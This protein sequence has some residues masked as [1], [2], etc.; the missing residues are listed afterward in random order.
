MQYL[1][2]V[3][4]RRLSLKNK[5]T[6]VV[7]FM[8]ANR[9][10]DKAISALAK[11]PIEFEEYL[12]H[13][14]A[15]KELCFAQ[16][17]YYQGY[18]SP[19]ELDNVQIHGTGVAYSCLS[20]FDVVAVVGDNLQGIVKEIRKIT[21]PSVI[22]EIYPILNEIEPEAKKQ[23]KIISEEWLIRVC[24]IIAAEIQRS[25]IPGTEFVFHMPDKVIVKYEEVHLIDPDI[26]FSELFGGKAGEVLKQRKEEYKKYIEQQSEKLMLRFKNSRKLAFSTLEYSDYFVAVSEEESTN[27]Q[28]GAGEQ[29][30]GIPANYNKHIMEL[31]QKEEEGYFNKCKE[32]YE[33]EKTNFMNTL[34]EVDDSLAD[35][36]R[37]MNQYPSQYNDQLKNYF[38]VTLPT[39][40]QQFRT[41]ITKIGQEE[42]KLAA[43]QA[44]KDDKMFKLVITRGYPLLQQIMAITCGVEENALSLYNTMMMSEHEYSN[45]IDTADEMFSRAK[46]MMYMTFSLV[47]DFVSLDELTESGN[48]FSLYFEPSR[49]EFEHAISTIETYSTY[50][51][52]INRNV[53]TF[54]N[55]MKDDKQFLN[56][57]NALEGV[58]KSLMAYDRL[59]RFY[60]PNATIC[61][62]NRQKLDIVVNRI[63]PYTKPLVS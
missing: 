57:F 23:T 3:K 60:E 21:I 47:T 63:R 15:M 32:T 1:K 37:S 19:E 13:S 49:I 39:Y 31:Q 12:K 45:M 50:M 61:R 16:A 11:S 9:L 5:N 25:R 33:K 59:I 22:N 38:R 55:I 56:R 62:D 24:V 29:K 2:A 40:I 28:L 18:M 41:A 7:L 8:G 35:V 20:R 26:S 27:E 52:S 36:E 14:K 30:P 48:R 46:N 10:Y 42:A 44:L 51:E 4:A 54:K 53:A 17:L 58:K 6:Y 34:V 43:W